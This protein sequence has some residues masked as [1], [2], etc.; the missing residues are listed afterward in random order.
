VIPHLRKTHRVLW[1]FAVE[2]KTGH[3]PG[4]KTWPLVLSFL[5]HTFHARVPADANPK[6]G[7]VALRALSEK[8]GHLGDAWDSAKGG[9][10]TLRTAAFE[11]IASDERP[12]TL[13]LLNAPF[14]ADWSSFQATGEVKR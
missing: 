10:Q 6:A 13:W 1:T 4:E 12:R 9:Y 5:R 3:G 7:T 2:P 11:E 14:A 8:D